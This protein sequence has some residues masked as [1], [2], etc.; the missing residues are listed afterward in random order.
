LLTHSRISIGRI[1]AGE[2]SPR[3]ANVD[4]ILGFCRKFDPSITYE[5][6]FSVGEHQAT[7]KPEQVAS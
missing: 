2:A 3:K 5:Q 4:A 6:L 7:P 1:L